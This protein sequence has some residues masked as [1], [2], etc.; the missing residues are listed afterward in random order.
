MP[1]RTSSIDPALRL[2]VYCGN[3]NPAESHILPTWLD[4]VFAERSMRQMVAADR[5]TP[6]LGECFAQRPK[7]ACAACSSGWIDRLGNQARPIMER[8]LAG[9]HVALTP[10]QVGTVAGCICL[11]AM[12]AAF[13][14]RHCGICLSD[15]AHLRQT[16]QPPRNWSLFVA[17]LDDGAWSRACLHRPYRI[18]FAGHP[19]ATRSR[20]EAIKSQNTQLF[21][22]GIGPLFFHVF[23]TPS[24]PLL[25]DFGRYSHKQGL[26]QLWPLPRRFGVM[27]SGGVTL[28]PALILSDQQA[29]ELAD[30]FAAG[31]RRRMAA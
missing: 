13:L 22:I 6:D 15:R 24:L 26:T 2:C 5:N 9:E 17:G 11:V 18:E 27:K 12:N 20:E 10:E 3:P 25:E 19:L 1:I 4:E 31:L 21:C 28:P 29:S 8:V 16:G 14:T 23:S 30:R 7:L